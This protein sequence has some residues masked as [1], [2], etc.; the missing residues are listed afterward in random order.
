MT[1]EMKAKL[2]DVIDDVFYEFQKAEG[3]ETGDLDP[4]LQKELEDKIDALVE[5]MDLCMRWQKI[6]N[7]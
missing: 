4:L 6:F 3:I 5:T 1:D 7:V 2:E